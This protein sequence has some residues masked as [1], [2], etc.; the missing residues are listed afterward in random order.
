VAASGRLT[1]DRLIA[2]VRGEFAGFAGSLEVGDDGAIASGA[3][4]AAS[5]NT[6]EPQCDEHLRSP[7][8]FDAAQ[9]PG[10]KFN[11]ALGSGNMHKV[12]PNL[13]ISAVKQS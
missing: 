13:D 1:L 2:T 11:Q 8:F 10:M 9:Y 3:V 4:A 12:K 6:K 5:V 7:D